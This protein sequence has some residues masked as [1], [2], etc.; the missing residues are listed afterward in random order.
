MNV[1]IDF[2]SG[3]GGK[4]TD[5]TIY[6]EIILLISLELLFLPSYVKRRFACISFCALP[7]RIIDSIF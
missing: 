5:P 1:F 2:A 7:E 6:Y 4:L 3:T